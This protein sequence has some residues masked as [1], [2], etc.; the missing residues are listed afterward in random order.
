MREAVVGHLR[1]VDPTLAQR[2]ADGLGMD[3][4]PP[5]PEAQVPPQDLDL[6]PAL[7]IIDR[8]RDTLEGRCIGILVHDGSDGASVRAL[9]KAAES[10]G[11][12]VRIVAPKLGGATLGNGE[13]LA[14]D[15]QLAGT[16]SA[17]F[18]A[19]AVVLSTDAG[20]QLA[21]ESAAVDWVRDAYGH[22]KAIA[23][24][25]GARVLLKAGGIGSDAGIV[26]AGDTKAFIAAAKTRQW[27][28]E[29]RVRALP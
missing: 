12:M 19:V 29:K 21:R 28:R 8:M 5:A 3:T 2:V 22:L 9:R 24:D 1:H 16:P 15:G 23:V 10:A 18:D 13:K 11:A 4:L 6:S 20:K 26:E 17:V 14:A 27:D 25:A 7:R